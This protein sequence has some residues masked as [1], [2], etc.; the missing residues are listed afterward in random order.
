MAIQVLDIQG[1]KINEKQIP[2]E[3][4]VKA[5]QHLIWEV[6][7]AEQAGR[8]Q[9]THK[10]KEKGEVRGGGKKPWKQ[11]GTG[12]ARAGSNRSPIWKGGG[13]TFG[14]RPRDYAMSLPRK[15]KLAGIVNILAH[16]I[17][18]GQVV[19]LNEWKVDKI[20]TKSAHE[21]F[22]S[23]IQGSPFYEEYA[24]DRK[25]RKNTNDRRRK[26]TVILGDDQSEKKLSLR[27][28]PWIES[29][30]VDRLAALPLWYNHGLIIMDD[31]FEKLAEKT[32]KGGNK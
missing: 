11:K 24:K 29:I 26:V 22:S 15:K 30:H 10:T 14:P 1:K 16:K 13:T 20:N 23:L 31:A 21:G 4:M 8:R 2:Q 17:S 25:I 3:L 9:G 27:N 28:I 18:Q 32:K 12:R 6:V 19:I 7:T 5:N